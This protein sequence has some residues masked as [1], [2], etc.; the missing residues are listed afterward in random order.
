[1]KTVGS[2]KIRAFIESNSILWFNLRSYVKLG[3]ITF[4][5]N[6]QIQSLRLVKI[7]QE[8]YSKNITQFIERNFHIKKS[9]Y[10]PRGGVGLGGVG[11]KIILD[12]CITQYLDVHLE[13]MTNIIALEY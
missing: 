1:M 5:N 11:V 9:I 10:R 4:Q 13:E 3:S 6:H 2:L 12:F 7:T 8:T